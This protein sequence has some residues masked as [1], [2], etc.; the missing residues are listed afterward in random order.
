MTFTYKTERDIAISSY[1]TALAHAGMLEGYAR[2]LAEQQASS[3]Y[4]NTCRQI[5]W[6]SQRRIRAG[7]RHLNGSACKFSAR[8]GQSGGAGQH[9]RRYDL[10][11][12]A[13]LTDHQCG[14]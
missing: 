13:P 3:E 11:T 1:N 5:A 10:L 7:R 12:L 6:R 8:T 9:R 4:W 14:G 2:A